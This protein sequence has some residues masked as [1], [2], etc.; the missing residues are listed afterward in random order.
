M[1]NCRLREDPL[2]SIPRNLVEHIPFARFSKMP[3]AFLVKKVNIATGKRSWSEIPDTARGES[4]DV[5]IPGECVVHVRVS[6]GKLTEF[7]T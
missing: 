6:H 3:R 4:G 5:C 1:D 2:K 7:S